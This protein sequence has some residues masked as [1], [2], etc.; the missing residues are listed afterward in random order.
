VTSPGSDVVS[1]VSVLVQTFNHERYIAEALDSVLEQR[2]VGPFEVLVGDDCSTDGTRSVIDAYARRHPGVVQPF[3]PREN[4]GGEGK[5]LFAE[6]V[7]RSR[8]RYIAWLDGDDYWTCPDKLRIQTRYLDLHPR[9]SMCFHNAVRRTDGGEVP[10]VLYNPPD[11]PRRVAYGDLFGDNPVAA[12]APVFRRE[13]I[14]PL[15]PWYF[16]LPW[17]DLPLYLVAA[18]RGE[19][20][21]LPEV[22]GVYRIHSHGMYSG[23]SR[24]RQHEL[25]IEFFDGLAGVVRASEDGHRR[26]RL[27]IALTRA[28]H[29]HLK[30]GDRDAAR[31][32][33][34]ESFRVWPID[35]RRLRGGAG[36][37]RR[38]QLWVWL[39]APPRR[40]ARSAGST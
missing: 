22:M 34:R 35:P 26:R 29:E 21:Y 11:R 5:I 20:H 9:C 13:V 4:M 15:P 23:V 38:L 39:H 6:L 40:R 10:D 2:G 37:L 17:G 30:A 12:C 16:R 3:Y 31:R 8:G 32:Q 14:D 7:A 28:A 24:L 25:D 19:V 36:E 1:G 27:S 33:L 18:Q